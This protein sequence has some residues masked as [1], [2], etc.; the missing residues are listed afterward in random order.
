MSVGLGGSTWYGEVGIPTI[1][2]PCLQ[3]T[4]FPLAQISLHIRR[5]P[6]RGCWLP[7]KKR[8]AAII[9]RLISFD[10]ALL[11]NS[12]NGFVIAVALGQRRFSMAR[13]PAMPDNA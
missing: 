4:L 10:A 5:R 6:V 11:L 2:S 12:G 3:S 9:L 8:F 7:G 1:I 13:N